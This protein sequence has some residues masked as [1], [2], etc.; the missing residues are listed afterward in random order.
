MGFLALLTWSTSGTFYQRRNLTQVL[1]FFISQF[2]F[3]NLEVIPDLFRGHPWPKKPIDDTFEA[4]R[5]SHPYD[6][7]RNDIKATLKVMQ[8]RGYASRLGLVGFCFGGGRVMDEISLAEEGLNPTTAVVFY[9][10]S[11]LLHSH[12]SLTRLLDNFNYSKKWSDPTM[13][14][15]L[16]WLTLLYIAGFDPVSVGTNSKASLLFIAGDSDDLVPK[17]TMETLRETLR[18]EHSSMKEWEMIVVENAGHA[19]AHRPRTEADKVDSVWLLNTA[20]QWLVKKLLAS[21]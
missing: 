14:I 10:T 5:D 13:W 6:R 7:I 16:Y 19:F 2:L 11:T 12:Q 17:N 8:D 21:E 4:W 18:S 9:P 1:C 15:I 3:F 20:T